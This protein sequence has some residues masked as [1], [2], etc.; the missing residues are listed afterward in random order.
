MNWIS[1]LK[2]HTDRF[3]GL[4]CGTIAAIFYSLANV[5]VQ[6]IYYHNKDLDLSEFQIIFVYSVVQIILSIVLLLRNRINPWGDTWSVFGLLWLAGFARSCKFIFFIVSLINLPLGDATVIMFTSPVFTIVL[7]IVFL[8]EPCSIWNLIFGMVSLLG[9][10]IMIAPGLF[11]TLKRSPAPYHY[12]HDVNTNQT[13]TAQKYQ[14][15]ADYEKGAGFGIAAAFSSSLYMILMK[16][17]TRN[18]SYRVFSLC[19]NILGMMLPVLYMLITKEQIISLSYEYWILNVLVG[20]LY[21]IGMMLIAFALFLE[22]AGQIALTRYSEI[23]FAFIFQVFI[24]K[25]IPV[26]YSIV[27]IV[28]IVLAASLIV[29][30]RIFNIEERICQIFPDC[31]SCRTKKDKENN[32]GYGLV[33]ND[34]EK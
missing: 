29:L 31:P 18:I 13:V 34:S 24:E 4:I 30:N 5:L 10:A 23:L 33:S 26:L 20:F 3:T 2:E 8:R 21:F 7:G 28:L 6:Y 14:F 16:F 27:G 25:Q 15:V 22:D 32:V 9:V 12:I 11:F 1:K 17:N 19:P